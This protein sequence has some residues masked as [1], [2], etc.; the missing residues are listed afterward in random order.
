MPVRPR[1]HGMAIRT[2][3]SDSGTPRA[4]TN[5]NVGLGCGMARLEV[6]ALQAAVMA[7]TREQKVVG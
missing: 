3:P 6:S 1:R 5:G 7:M 4:V 2:G